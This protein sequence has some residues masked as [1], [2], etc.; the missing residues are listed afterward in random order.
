MNILKYTPD[1]IREVVGG[2]QDTSTV[3]H[4][5]VNTLQ[6]SSVHILNFREAHRQMITL[7][8]HGV[9]IKTYIL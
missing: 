6:E 3:S 5:N 2:D 4:G 9:L 8:Y 1:T 7:C